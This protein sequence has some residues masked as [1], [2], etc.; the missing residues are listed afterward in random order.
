MYPVTTNA[1]ITTSLTPALVDL[2]GTN[3]QKPP[4]TAPID[5]PQPAY[6]LGS[7][8]VPA[9]TQGTSDSMIAENLA[10]KLS[11]PYLV[12]YSNIMTPCVNQY[13]GG[14]NQMQQLPAIAY[15]MVN[16]A[17]N[18][19][20]FNN[21]SDLTFTVLKPYVLTEIT[22]SV[23]LPNGE[24]A[25]NILDDNTAV[26]YRIDFKNRIQTEAQQGQ[27]E[28]KNMLIVQKAAIEDLKKHAATVKQQ[29]N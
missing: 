18:D 29:N 24:L 13:V 19:Y 25:E 14:L 10:Q 15:L 22:T 9:A 20:I 7:N 12:L 5:Q 4:V 26:I 6:N 11:F 23:H 8:I 28:L 27:A 2:F 3:S 1:L 21:R 16:Y 17:T